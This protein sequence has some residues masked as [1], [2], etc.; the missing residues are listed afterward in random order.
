M[1]VSE[2]D[3]RLSFTLEVKEGLPLQE[4]EVFDP[5]TRLGDM[6]T[7]F[8]VYLE[9]RCSNLICSQSE[10]RWVPVIKLL[11]VATNRG[12]AIAFDVKEHSAYGGLDLL[13]SLRSLFHTP[14]EELS[15]TSS[16]QESSSST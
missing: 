6:P 5:G 9:S 11:G 7:Q 3:A 10:L 16:L 1:T 13:G 15:H 8:L 14:L 12:D 4:G 2:H